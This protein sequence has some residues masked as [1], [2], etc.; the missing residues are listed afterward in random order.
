MKPLNMLLIAGGGYA[1]YWW[2]THQTPAA[3][4]TTGGTAAG[5]T[6]GA[7]AGTNTGSTTGGALAFNSLDAIYKRTAA[8]VSAAYGSAPQTSDTFNFFLQQELPAGVV[9]PD[10]CA[11][12]GAACGRDSASPMTLANYWG[13]MAPYLRANM[14]LSGLGF[15]GGLA[16]LAYASRAI[17]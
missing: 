7:T 10:P 3:P 15:Y 11:V 17:Q 13:A 12:F 1:L 8:K 9:A 16:G 6:A 2:L 4:T 5:A 14:G